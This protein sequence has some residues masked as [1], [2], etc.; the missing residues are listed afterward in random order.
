MERFSPS[1]M[2][3]HNMFQIVSINNMCGLSSQ[4][5]FLVD[6]LN[7][8]FFF[9]GSH[10]WHAIYHRGTRDDC[11]PCWSW[12]HAKEL[13]FLLAISSLLDLVYSCSC[14]QYPIQLYGYGF[15]FASRSKRALIGA[16]FEGDFK[17]DLQWGY[18]LVEGT[19][20]CEHQSKQDD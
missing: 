20:P 19:P 8:H 16:H 9:M 7:S 4:F 17:R 5:V 6:I 12:A 3:A 2:R 1:V 10:L 15:H 13:C 14:S 11:R 18:Y